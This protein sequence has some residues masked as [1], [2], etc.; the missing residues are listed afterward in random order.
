MRQVVW[1][2]TWLSCLLGQVFGYH[3]ARIIPYSGKFSRVKEYKTYA[4]A[5]MFACLH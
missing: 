3:E 2:Y 1:D 5:K 4:T